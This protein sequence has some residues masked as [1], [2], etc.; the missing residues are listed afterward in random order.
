MAVGDAVL[1]HAEQP[2]SQNT[3]QKCRAQTARVGS[4]RRSGVRQ[5]HRH[6]CTCHY[7]WRYLTRVDALPGSCRSFSGGSCR[8]VLRDQGHDLAACRDRRHLHQGRET[9]SAMCRDRPGCEPGV[10]PAASPA[11]VIGITDSADTCSYTCS[12]RVYGVQRPDVWSR[13]YPERCQYDHE[14]G[15]GL[16]HREPDQPAPASAGHRA[17]TPTPP[18]GAAAPRD[19]PRD[20]PGASPCRNFSYVGHTI[21]YAR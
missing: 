18:D 4:W 5:H 11:R 20:L 10:A 1:S 17:A 19:R 13:C 3:N 6:C 16:D 15:P 8:P 12:S 2:G 9:R 21:S 7:R 14:W